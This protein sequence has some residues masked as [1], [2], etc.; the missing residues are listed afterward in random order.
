[1]VLD[2]KIHGRTAY[3]NNNG[4]AFGRRFYI[5][6][7]DV[8]NGGLV[9]TGSGLWDH[10]D[11]GDGLFAKEIEAMD[12]ALKIAGLDVPATPRIRMHSPLF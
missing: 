2:F 4:W 8:G 6:S 7:E 11:E 3:L 12:H 10:S 5:A 9:L 1:M